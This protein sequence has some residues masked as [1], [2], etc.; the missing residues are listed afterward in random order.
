MRAMSTAPR[1]RLK[2]KV[3]VV[4]AGVMGMACALNLAERGAEVIVLDATARIA[5][6]PD[7]AASG[8]AAG[9]IGPYSESLLEPV[10]AH[11]RA[12]E[13][14]V[15]SLGLWPAFAQRLGQGGGGFARR[16]ALVVASGGAFAGRL[17]KLSR[18][19]RELGAR[20]RLVSRKE[21]AALA[22]ALGSPAD[23]GVLL[24]DEAQIAPAPALTAAILALKRAGGT[25]R[26]GEVASL[27]IV[28]PTCVGVRLRAREAGLIAAD[29]V[30]LAP[31][32]FAPP[33]LIDQAPALEHIRPAKGHLIEIAVEGGEIGQPVRGERLYLLSRSAQV[34]RVGSTMEF[35]KRDIAVDPEQVRS[36]R[37]ELARLAPGLADAPS[38]SQW[39]GVRAMSPDWSPIL[40]RSGAE[41][42]FVAAAP[43]RNGWLLAPIVAEIISKLVFDEPLPPLWAAFGPERFGTPP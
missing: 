31:G 36:L 22:P 39:A 33:T 26:A 11:P 12:L 27:E 15:E 34:L 37:A 35:G 5:G 21:I 18:R 20:G 28:G 42:V 23:F 10:E 16:G 4:G 9:L 41:N 3:A 30:V 1:P 40:G 32:A 17:L 25:V 43:S 8:R 13:L 6:P 38:L 7:R 24:E 2:P 14:G 29:A 19:A